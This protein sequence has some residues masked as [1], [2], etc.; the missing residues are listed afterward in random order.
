MRSLTHVLAVPYPAQGHVIPMME[1]AKKLV[2]HGCKVTFANTD[3]IHRRVTNA[4]SSKEEDDGNDDNCGNKLK[5]VS[6]PDGLEHGDD[7]LNL[8]KLM[9]SMQRVM[10]RKLEELIR[11]AKNDENRRF[12]CV[13][14]EGGTGWALEVAKRMEIKTVSFCPVSAST[15]AVACSI[16]KLIE[17]GI[18]DGNDGSILKK[19]IF[20]IS[21][22]MPV[23]STSAFAWACFD[24]MMTRKS[25]FKLTSKSNE[26]V[27]KFADFKICNSANE[28]EPAAFSLLPELLPVG[29]LLA[30]SK[31]GNQGGNFWAK[32]SECL[33]WLDQQPAR[34]VIYVAFGSFTAFNQT[35]FQELALGLELTN[36][37]F[38][39]V[40]RP[41]ITFK[42]TDEGD[43]PQG[44]KE[45]IG[46]RGKIIST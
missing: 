31:L 15:A 8:E 45:R 22:T 14:A 11:K 37:P 19:Q 3:F 23:I 41:G 39:W 7:R 6:I 5:M 13:V 35:Q 24:D 34:S 20:N 18:I 21:P 32:D 38:L 2:H 1:F 25:L 4:M 36:K 44:Y 30:S 9:G 16:P 12:T 26:F 29:P 43:Y 33:S 46:C 27:E 42:E 40:A 17:D 28:L 10:P